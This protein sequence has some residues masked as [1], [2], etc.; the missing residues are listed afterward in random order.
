MGTSTIYTIVI[1]F[2]TSGYTTCIRR[3]HTPCHEFAHDVVH[4]VVFQYR[5]VPK[6]PTVINRIN[7]HHISRVLLLTT[8]WG[9]SLLRNIAHALDDCSL[10]TSGY[11]HYKF[12][13]RSL[14]HHYAHYVV[15][16]VGFLHRHITEKPYM[17]KIVS[18][19][20]TYQGLGS[21]LE[22]WIPTSSYKVGHALG[23]L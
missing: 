12:G 7:S 13:E 18:A 6:N 10:C 9:F 16:K 4:K 3:R 2:Y 15:H 19:F 5:R 14:C 11:Q 21:C 1:R 20:I 17:S 22:F 8:R 23:H